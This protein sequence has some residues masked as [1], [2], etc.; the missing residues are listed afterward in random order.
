MKKTLVTLALAAALPLSAHAELNFNGFANVVA[1]KASSGD[2]QWGYDDDV[3]FK[4]DSLFGLQATADLGEGLSATVQLISR[5]EED[6]ETDFEW[7]YLAY[8]ISEETRVILGRQRAN[9]YIYSGYLDVSYAYPWITPPEGVYSLQF[10]SFDGASISHSFNLGEFDTNVQAIYGSESRD[11]HI[12]DS[13]IYSTFDNIHG[14]NA[15]FN[16]DWLTLRAA[17]ISTDISMPHPIGTAIVEAWNQVPGFEY[18]GTELMLEEDQAQ[19]FE[20]GLQI[21]YNN[22]L[23]ISEYT[24]SDFEESASDSEESLYVTVGYRFDDVL[25]HATY[26]RD[27]NDAN[28]TV[29]ELPYGINAQL[30]QLSTATARVFNA[31]TEDSKTYS[32]G[33][34]WDFH[35]SAAFKV[36]Y[37]RLESDLTNEDTNL[38]RTA[39]VTVF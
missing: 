21:D 15:T 11:V 26:G 20:A 5:G 4:Q 39:L 6:W 35:E 16:R 2:E 22:W 12:L 13:D 1:G 9:L 28:P 23:V 32:L 36:E 7:A 3:D 25:V 33:A 29:N 8:D 24:Y 37:S 34:R 27:K 18:V 17:Y 10:T 30:D 19:F 38:V 31:R 14:F